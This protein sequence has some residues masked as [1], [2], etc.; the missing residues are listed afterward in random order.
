MASSQRIRSLA[1]AE[2]ILREWQQLFNVYLRLGVSTTQIPEPLGR[3]A[4]RAYLFIR[5]HEAKQQATRDGWTA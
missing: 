3:Q 1:Q 5:R 2:K 4:H